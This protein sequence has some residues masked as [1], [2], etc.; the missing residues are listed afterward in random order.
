MKL[1][2][3]AVLSGLFI[4][5]AL[6]MPGGS[7]VDVRNLYEEAEKAFEEQKYQEAI[8]KYEAAME[9]GKEWGADTSVIDEDFDN[10]AKYKIA[11]CYAKLGDQLDDPAMYEKSLEYIPEIYETTKV[12]KVREGLIFLWGNN[13]YEL[14]RYEE[15]EPKFRELLNDYP[16]SQFAEN[17][18]YSLG[19]L[20]YELNQYESARE[21]FKLVIENFP[22]SELI[23]SSQFSIG[24]SFFDESNY[25][26]A[27]LE[28]EKVESEN[29]ALLAQSRYYNAL[30]LLRMSRNQEAL[31]AYQRFIADFPE[32]RFIP[33][34]YFDMGTIHANLKEYDEATR[35]YE[36]AIQHT[37][38]ETTKGEIRFQIGNN[39]FN[40]EDYQS[41]IDAYQR[42][43]EEYPENINIPEA[44]FGIAESYWA[45]KDYQQAI[46]AYMV[47]L[48][49]DPDSENIP[50][51]NNRIAECYYQMDD[52]EMALEWYQKV[53]DNYP[54]SPVVKDATYGKIWALNDLGRYEEAESVANEYI[55]KYKSDETYD[56]AAAEAQMIIGD[57]KF[58]SENYL[59]AADAYLRVPTDYRDLPKFDPFKSRSLLQAGYAY[60]KEAERNDWDAGLLSQAADAFS[61]LIDQYMTNFDVGTREFDQRLDY[62]IPGIINLSLSYSK[63]N[64]FEMARQALDKMPKNNPEYGRAV[65]LKGQTYADEENVDEAVAVYRQMVG[66]DSLSSTWKSRAA[67]EMATMLRDVGRHAEAV[68]E[69]QRIAEDYPDSE[70]VPQSMYLIGASYYDIEPRTPENMDKAIE[71]FRNALDKYPNSETAPWSYLGILLAYEA[72]NDFDMVVKIADE[73]EQQYAD[74]DIEEAKQVIDHARRRKVD[75]MTKLEEGVATDILIAELRKIV[76]DPVG[77]ESGKAAALMRI[78]K[79]LFDE[80]RYAEAIKEYETL[81]SDFP[82]QSDASARY[83]IAVAAYWMEDYQKAVDSAQ[84][85]LEAQDANVDLKTGMNYTLGL[86]YSRLGNTN[87]AIASLKQAIQI[88]EGAESEQT[89]ELVFAAHRELARVYSDANQYDE[90]VK[91]YEF[92]ANNSLTDAEKAEAN[93]W[94]ARAYEENMQ[95]YQAAVDNYNKV[96]QFDTS[97]ILTAQ[98]LYYSGVLYSK[99]LGDK[100]KALDTFRELLDKFANHQDSNVQLMVTDANLRIPEL[101]VELG[102]FDEAVARAREV[103]D[104]ALKGD[105]KEKKVNTQY[106][107]AYLLG[108]QAGQA[109][110]AGMVDPE[111]SREA[112]TEYAKVYEYA[113][114]ITQASEEIKTLASASLYN[115]GYLLYGLEQYDDYKQAVAYFKSFTDDFKNSENYSAALEYLGFASFEMARL[116]ADLDEFARAAEF[117]LR[118]AREFPKHKDAPVT[119]FQAGEAYFAVGG[120]HSY[121]A[122]EATDPA[123]RQKELDAS[124]EAYKKA[125][126]AHRQLVNNF[127]NS[128]YA[129]EALYVMAASYQYIS[130]AAKEDPS[131]S[132]QY[133]ENR[134]KM[135]AAY[136]E[137]AEK[138]PQSEYAAS[139]FLSVGNDYYNQAAAEDVTIEER[140]ELYKKSLEN[141]RKALQVPGTEAKM[142]MT[143]EAYVRETE[144][145]LAKDIYNTGAALVP[146]ADT[147]AAR[148]ANKT[149]APKAIPYFKEVV[150]TFPNTDFADLSYVQLG[151]CY[152]YLEDWENAENAYGDLIKK[153]TDENGNP[154][155]PFSEGVVRALQYARERKGQIMAYRIALKARQQSEGQ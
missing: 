87:D 42:L 145:L 147:E 75:A 41:A 80:K 33:A 79:I 4:L 66:D 63:M 126:N 143:I 19:T 151:M 90:A 88:G 118:F 109:A 121:N 142:K 149:N 127:P 20:Y 67:I 129:P 6:F 64:E 51:A 61:R 18:Y 47:V 70:F 132:D 119:T 73:I 94:L 25:D 89:K 111:L 53:I 9:E 131:K 13:Y 50:L 106:Q 54:D 115:A 71:A 52:K 27:H 123:V 56:I 110:D 14:E 7:S 35:N 92:L 91:E 85:G 140:T 5:V 72:K 8:S 146:L 65:F 59:D 39:Y 10:L 93:F 26:Q 134:R 108:E 62:V 137:L 130:E 74:S 150:E 37:K 78:G 139:A 57:I 148:E 122:Q 11:V 102:N 155:T 30:S 77:E 48:E 2:L 114:P 58:D 34:A 23:D 101:L 98:S 31:T 141:Y 17:A 128:E 117:F 100:Q 44:R 55:A 97:E 15:A 49:K 136:R 116:T 45:L 154:I 138:Y 68:V 86:A 28:F 96:I 46:D 43:I 36:L 81:L 120:G 153:Y 3:V 107:L 16:D 84:K 83:Q 82:G 99:Q 104:E 24:M 103:R 112:A 38:D 125:I 60:Y 152:E 76:E 22:N 144:E 40:Q 32:S 69:Y 29:Q 133:E 113:K 95:N 105:D 1:K 135:N 12:A 124:V 21:A